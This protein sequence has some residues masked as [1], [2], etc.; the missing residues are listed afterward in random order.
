MSITVHI[1]LFSLYNVE[2]C[3]LKEKKASLIFEDPEE[4]M[5][6]FSKKGNK[7][8]VSCSRRI[9]SEKKTPPCALVMG[10][11][12]RGRLR[13]TN[14]QPVTPRQ[15]VHALKSKEKLERCDLGCCPLLLCT[16]VLVF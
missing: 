15:Y 8:C 6:A 4:R 16:N 7:L 5:C 12:V 1:G 14:C 13:S 2:C 10:N 11:R 3:V 9:S